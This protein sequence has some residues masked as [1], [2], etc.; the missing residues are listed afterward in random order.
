MAEMGYFVGNCNY[1]MDYSGL[2]AA[3][4]KQLYLEADHNGFPFIA[5]IYIRNV[6]S[7]I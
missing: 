6:G 1:G 3:F 2:L 4:P 5:P 7:G